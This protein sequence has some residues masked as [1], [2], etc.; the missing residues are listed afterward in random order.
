MPLQKW[1]SKTLKHFSCPM[2]TKTQVGLADAVLELALMRGAESCSLSSNK[3]LSIDKFS[4]L[5][6]KYK[7]YLF[8]TFSFCYRKSIEY[9][10]Y[11][12]LRKFYEFTFKCDVVL[13]TELE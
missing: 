12:H 8:T 2:V 9:N 6:E 4:I 13:F 10:I 3:L 7:T 11:F 5:I 1:L